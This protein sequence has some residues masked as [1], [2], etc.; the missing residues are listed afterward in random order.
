MVQAQTYNCDTLDLISDQHAPIDPYQVTLV[1][2][3]AEAMRPGQLP[4]RM[5]KNF[6]SEKNVFEAHFSDRRLIRFSVSDS[7]VGFLIFGERNP[8]DETRESVLE[9][10]ECKAD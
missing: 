5:D 3:H 9:A 6:Q 2:G 4:V 8:I 7:N 1:D 10:F